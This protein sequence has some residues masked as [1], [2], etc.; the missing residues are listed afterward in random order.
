MSI[1]TKRSFWCDD[2]KGKREPSECPI[3]G[4]KND[5]VPICE[6]HGLEIHKRTF[7]YYNGG[8]LQDK[9]E[10]RLR[11]FLPDGREFLETWILRNKNKAET[12][13]LGSE[14]SEDALTWNVFGELHR[15]G[16]IHLAYNFFTGEG[17]GTGQVKLFLWG[18]ELDFVGNKAKPC[19]SLEEVRRE[20]EKGIKRFL[21]EPDIMLL[22]PNELILIEA[23]F[24]SGNPVCI[25]GTDCADEKPK[26]RDSLIQRYIENNK[27]WEPVLCR[28]DVGEKVHSQLL[29][30]IVFASTMAQIMDKQQWKVINLVSRTRWDNC[31]HSKGYDHRDPTEFI[32]TRVRDHFQFSY[33]EHLYKETL[34]SD[35][36]TAEIA[37]Y[38][39]RKSANLS[40]AFKFS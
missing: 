34:A 17:V 28:Q 38:M 37:E 8:T 21:T 4:C 20:L 30:M 18:L 16:L 11:N 29:R 32:P 26:S 14:N 2:L 6:E 9:C 19:E 3:K 15:C 23:K 7:V 39:Q 5:S 35:P 22:G 10:A 36:R 27:L 31:A 24:T 13:R 12:H 25:E 33:W 1:T 40:K